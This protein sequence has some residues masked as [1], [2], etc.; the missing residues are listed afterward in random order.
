[1]ALMYCKKCGR[2]IQ[3]HYDDDD[4]TP[5]YCDCCNS[6]TYKVPIEFLISESDPIINSDSEQQFIE[7]YIISSSEFDQY[8]FDHREEILARQS[9]EFNAKMEQGKA[10][11]EKQS[12]LPECPTCH[13]KNVQSISGIERGASIIGLGIFSKKINKSYK[14][15]HCGYTW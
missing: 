2:L 5:C 4:R 15:K 9:A 1:M 14:C 3:G 11:L 13:S 8:L 6:V 7:K 10:I 12:R